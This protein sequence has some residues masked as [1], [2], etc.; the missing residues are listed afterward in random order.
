VREILAMIDDR[1]RHP[2]EPD[3]L[4]MLVRTRD[5]DSSAMT[6]DDV[7]G[8][9][10]FLFAASYETVANALT[11]TMFLVAQHPNVAAGLL[12][13]LT[14]EGAGEPACPEA[15][16]RL[17]LL[18]AVIKE[19]LRM[20]P[21]VPMTLRYATR[22]LE[23]AGLKLRRADRVICSHYVTHHLAELFP[24]PERFDPARWQTIRPG[25]FEYLPF[26][27]GP[28][29]CAGS[30]LATTMMKLVLSVILPAWRLEVVPQAR[31]DRSIRVTLGPKF[32]MPV[33]LHRQDRRFSASPVRG[34]IHEMV[35]LGEVVQCKD[36]QSS[37]EG[38]PTLGVGRPVGVDRQ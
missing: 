16:E 36:R 27:A 33:V 28:H 23:L 31:I 34:N 4:D 11:W 30:H 12:D 3:M 10:A 37:P 17:P 1:R 32:G 6:D 5:A 9:T 8:Q 18:D 24:E 25:P 29:Y 15:L 19:S 20:L 13:E 22:P 21:P 2:A 14:G 38:S 7:L 35:Q 26:G